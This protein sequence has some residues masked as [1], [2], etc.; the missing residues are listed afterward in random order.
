MT[1]DIELLPLPER[2]DCTNGNTPWCQGCYTMTPNEY[3]D[4][5]QWE[6][7]ERITAAQAAEI[8]R[9]R[10]EVA[11]ERGRREHTQQWYAV[12][13]AKI[14]DVAKR[15]GLWPEVAAIFA[16]GSGTRQL[17]DGSYFYDPPTYAQQLNIAKHRATA[18]EARAERLAEA[19]REKADKWD[20]IG[21]EHGVRQFTGNDHKL[22][23]NELRALLSDHEQEM[24]N[25]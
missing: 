24:S 1:A 2:F 22:F 5:V 7:Y 12:R 16:N 15:E 21:D 20:R 25:G 13:N 4:Y 19:L 3:G 17:P 23:A 14:E 8:E 6:D 10:A 11:T 18:A 9:L